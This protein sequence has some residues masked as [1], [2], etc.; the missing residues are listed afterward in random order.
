IVLIICTIYKIPA[1]IAIGVSSLVATSLAFIVNHIPFTQLWEYWFEGYTASTNFEPVN[2]LLSKGGMNSMLFTVSLVIL[3]L[4]FGGLLFV[5]GIIPTML[6]SIQAKL[7]KL[8]LIILST[9]AT[10]IGIN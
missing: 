6:A 5:T 4:G 1:F 9:A 10:A 2:D 7:K 8:R 3:A